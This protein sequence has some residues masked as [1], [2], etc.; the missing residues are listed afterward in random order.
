MSDIEN[1]DI[2]Q[3]QDSPERLAAIAGKPHNT[4]I[5]ADEFNKIVSAIKYIRDNYVLKS[6]S[7]KIGINN[8]NPQYVLDVANLPIVITPITG[9]LSL[10][11]YTLTGVGSLF[12]TEL[13]QYSFIRN[14]ATGK[15]YTVES[16]LS[17]TEAFCFFD[18]EYDQNGDID[19]SLTNF[20]NQKCEVLVINQN[21][22]NVNDEFRIVYNQWGQVQYLMKIG[23]LTKIMLDEMNNT[24]P[25]QQDV[26][27]VVDIFNNT[28]NP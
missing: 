13:Q 1:F 18:V 7:G 17:D 5:F 23:N 10:E 4:L 3:K 11:N 24:T 19:L 25:A 27:T 8:T 21:L 26:N 14:V 2:E 20:Q 6:L 22:F 15:I 28:L 12:T 16:I 9:I